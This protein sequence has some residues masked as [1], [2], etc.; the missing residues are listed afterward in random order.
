MDHDGGHFGN[1]MVDFLMRIGHPLLID[2]KTHRP[3]RCWP[4]EA[5]KGRAVPV[6]VDLR[7]REYS[8]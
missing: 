8:I 7:F 2:G 1:G 3:A 5:S 6:T 4:D